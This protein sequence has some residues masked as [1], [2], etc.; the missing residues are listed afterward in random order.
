MIVENYE[1][2]LPLDVYVAGDLIT[3]ASTFDVLNANPYQDEIGDLSLEKVEASTSNAS[4]Q[5]GHMMWKLLIIFQRNIM[6]QYIRNI[7]HVGARLASYSGLSMVVGA[8]FWQVGS[9]DSDRGLTYE[10][11]AS[12]VVRSNIFLL[13]ISYLLPFATIPVF[14]G[15]KRFLPPK[16]R[17]G[18]TPPW[19]YGSSQLLL[20]FAFLTLASTTRTVEAI[21][22]IPMCAMWNVSLPMWGSFLTLLSVLIVS[23]LVGSTIVLCCSMWLPTQDLAFLLASTIRNSGVVAVN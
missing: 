20:A 21:I 5:T 23:G 7:A 6:N 3:K 18:Y 12:L 16:V 9:S 19:M 13:N 8:I 17:L 15:N 1:E 2:P 4:N 10:E 11:A 22:V 14:V